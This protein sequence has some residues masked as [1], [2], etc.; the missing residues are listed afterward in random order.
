MK[1]TETRI[2]K[3]QAKVIT[4]GLFGLVGSR[5]YLR[6]LEALIQKATL[7]EGKA[8]RELLQ[9]LMVTRALS[10]QELGLLGRK[11]DKVQREGQRM[12]EAL[13]QANQK[14]RNP[15]AQ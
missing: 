9:D 12:H 3:A 6:D 13:I 11:F 4:N 1:P 8:L 10:Q 14:L 2:N 7:A 5:A 15:H